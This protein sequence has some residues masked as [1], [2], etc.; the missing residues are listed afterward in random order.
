MGL[1]QPVTWVFGLLLVYA[2]LTPCSAE[3]DV[4][5]EQVQ[6]P[7]KMKCDVCVAVQF[8]KL[9]MLLPLSEVGKLLV[10]NSDSSALHV[11]PK[12]NNPQ[13]GALFLSVGPEKLMKRYRD[14][15][16]LQGLGIK[17]N[18]QLF[19]AL[20]KTPAGNKSISTIRRIEHIDKADR[21]LKTSKESLHVY[22]IK[23]SPPNSQGVYFVIDGHETVY[24]LA[25]NVTQRLYDAVLSNILVVNVP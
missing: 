3:N 17:T 4:V 14:S 24:L 21:Y 20:G 25:G 7:D 23:S 11:L 5:L 19:D 8:G 13:E 1:K 16:L 18:E 15:G 22:W 12:T 9:E 10:I 2:S 6:W